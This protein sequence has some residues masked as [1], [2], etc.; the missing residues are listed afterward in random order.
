[1]SLQSDSLFVCP[2]SHSTRNLFENEYMIFEDHLQHEPV[3]F[4]IKTSLI[5][6]AGLGVFATESIPKD[7]ASAYRGVYCKTADRPERDGTYEWKVEGWTDELENS[8][9][10]DAFDSSVWDFVGFCDAAGGDHWTRYVNCAPSEAAANVGTFSALD[11]S[12]DTPKVYYITKRIIEAGEELLVYYGDEAYQTCIERAR[13]A[14][15]SETG[16][17][18]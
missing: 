4:E 16:L 12:D 2:A 7:M 10:D 6:Y 9:E 11:A 8:S 17:S 15:R 5:P 3:Q 18:L 1:M 14:M 13:A